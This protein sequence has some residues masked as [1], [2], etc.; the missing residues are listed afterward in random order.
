MKRA[1]ILWALSVLITLGVAVYQRMTGP[2]YPVR[3]SLNVQG[4]AVKYKLLRSHGG[5]DDA[6]LEVPLALS[7]EAPQITF[8]RYKSGEDWTHK[9]LHKDKDRWVFALPHQPPAGKL[10]YYLSLNK[11]GQSLR[12]PQ[13]RA[14][15]IRFKGG[16]P[17]WVLIPHILFMFVAML[18]SSRAGLEALSKGSRLRLYA[19]LATGSLLVGGMILGPIVQKFA[20]GAL[21]TGVPFGYDLTDNKT[22]IAALAWIAALVFMGE[23]QRKRARVLVLSAVLVLYAIYSI[24]HSLLGSELDNKTGEIV[25]GD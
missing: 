17:P 9:S 15:V 12:I 22:L 18:L 1:I 23:A 8:R 6:R 10:E 5:D 11:N 21:W 14:V 7:A 2:T 13:D 4:Q 19:W 25:T 20:F 3:G 24:P 16:V